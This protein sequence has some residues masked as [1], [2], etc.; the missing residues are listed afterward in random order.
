[1]VARRTEPPEGRRLIGPADEAGVSPHLRFPGRSA[2]GRKPG[3]V[4]LMLHGGKSASR[5]PVT[6]TNLAALRMSRFAPA[7]ESA[8]ADRVRVALL[9][10]RY[11][12]WKGHG[13]DAEP[14]LPD[15]VRDARWALDR[16]ADRFGDQVPVVLA[17]HSLGGRVAVRVADHPTVRAVVALAPWLPPGEP[18]APLAGRTL[19]V[20]HGDQDR[21]TGPKA[22]AA[23]A[24]QAAPL[25][26]AT[27]VR[28]L[29]GCG[30]A[31]L[32]DAGVWHRTVRDFTLGVLGELGLLGGAGLPGY[33][34]AA[35]IDA[36]AADT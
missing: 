30:H 22:S 17:G 7:F 32:R 19:L 13:D 14:Q 2:D 9:R 16:V 25:T 18:T 36:A 12:G 1:M 29:E 27:Y 3:A 24:R 8:P 6:R 23:F 20:V 11:R 21:V 33:L 5:E 28:L 15:P 34:T 10:Y 35:R 4:I 26:T 31:M